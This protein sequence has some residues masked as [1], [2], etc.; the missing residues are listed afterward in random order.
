MRARRIII[1]KKQVFSTNHLLEDLLMKI[2]IQ[3]K[4]IH[5][6]VDGR[7]ICRNCAF[8][9]ASQFLSR[10]STHFSRR[11]WLWKNSGHQL[12]MYWILITC[13]AL[14]GLVVIVCEFKL[15]R[16]RWIFRVS[17]SPKVYYLRRWIK[18]WVPCCEILRHV[19][20]HTVW[21]KYF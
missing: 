17:K 2:C 9:W 21:N 14:G 6:P 1:L 15:G 10:S 4:P 20:K 3:A 13:V 11:D 7:G 5:R 8:L 18:P 16:G 19:K 12:P